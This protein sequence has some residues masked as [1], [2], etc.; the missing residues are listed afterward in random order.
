[1]LA[2]VKPTKI[3]EVT[4]SAQISMAASRARLGAQPRFTKAPEIQPP[5]IDP[6]VEA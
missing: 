3:T 2:W 6:T 4:A 1:M 5:P